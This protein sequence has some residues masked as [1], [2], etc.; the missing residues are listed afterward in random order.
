MNKVISV[1]RMLFGLALLVLLVW[2]IYYLILRTARGL[3]NLKSELAVAIIAA[4]ASVMVSIVSLVVS[5]ALDRRAALL[6]ELR[7]KKTPIY[8]QFISTLYKVVFASN[9]GKE[10][11]QE[12]LIEF[13]ADF[14]EKLTIWGSDDVIKAWRAFRLSLP[15]SAPISERESSAET[16]FQYESLLFAIRKDLGHKN[17]GFKKG[18]LLGLFVNDI[19]KYL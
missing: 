12:E 19:D 15:E 9:L 10:I 1:F 13:F 11:S 16:L 6:Q 2:G 4:S 5:K 8:E 3:S 7:A 17:Q 14:T 18:T